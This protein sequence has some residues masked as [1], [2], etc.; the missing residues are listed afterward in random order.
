MTN[1]SAVTPRMA[2]KQVAVIASA[3]AIE[4]YDLS[5]YALF[6]VAIAQNF[7]PAGHGASALLLTVATLGVGYVMRPLGGIVLGLYADRVGR[8]AAI[9]ITV[10]MMSFSTGI[11]A[12]I[13]S[14]AMIGLAAPLLI[15]AARLVQGFSSGGATAGSIAYLVESA[16]PGRR[17]FY[18][19]W[20]QA[21]QISAFLL[22]AAI[23]ALIARLFTPEQ[24]N[25]WAWRIPFLLALLFG[26]LG[27]YIKRSMPDPDRFRQ[28]R[29]A[30][31]PVTLASAVKGNF[32]PILTGFGVTCLWNITAF[33]LLFYMPTYVQANFALPL[34]DAFTASVISGAL[35]FLLCPF[36]G[37]LSDRIGRKPVMLT[38][39]VLLGLLIYPLLNHLAQRPTL[40]TLIQIQC[41]LAVLIAA[42]T[43]PV[44]AL[45]AELFP[46]RSRSTGLSIAYNLST[47][48]LGAF[49]PLIVTWL[50]MVTGDILSPAYYVAAG[51]ALSSV[52]LLTVRESRE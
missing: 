34:R 28:A 19:S 26:P 4:G 27:L 40:A 2:T 50:I 15:V 18:A 39:A 36:M 12:F 13:P 45:L 49:G 52:A 7:F 5:I 38:G 47:M 17:G 21:S 16:P 31:A 37:A 9:S 10:L 11:I 41:V 23:G 33:V 30:A 42:Y 29:E 14:H 35:L 24:M 3:V 25:G 1:Q 20:Q 46:I 44:S 8:K 43:A 32:R 51:A 6:A 22:S 48:I